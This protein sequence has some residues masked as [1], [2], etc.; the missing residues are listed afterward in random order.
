MNICM[1]PQIASLRKT[2]GN[3]LTRITL[4]AFGF[5]VVAGCG[6]GSSIHHSIP[7]EQTAATPAIATTAAQN[8]A[9]IVSLSDSTSGT[10]DSTTPSTAARLRKLLRDTSLPFLSTPTSR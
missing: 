2:I 7:A 5:V 1:L 3:L 6:G 9:V 4:S 10:N 8:G